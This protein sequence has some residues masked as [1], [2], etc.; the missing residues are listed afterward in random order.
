VSPEE[1]DDEDAF[2]LEF[3]V[4]S[5]E[6]QPNRRNELPRTKPYNA[7]ILPFATFV[8]FGLGGST[9]E[10]KRNETL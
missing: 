4:K 8:I 6:C 3:V 7:L 2:W 5:L 9:S 1:S 10:E